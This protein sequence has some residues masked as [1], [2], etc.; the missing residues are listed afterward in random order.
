MGMFID[1]YG[2]R[3]IVATIS[4]AILVIVHMQMALSDCNPIGPLVGQGLAYTGFVSVLWPAIPLV[5]EE[6]LLG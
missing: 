1:R 4:P 3:A 6:R 2:M 5:V